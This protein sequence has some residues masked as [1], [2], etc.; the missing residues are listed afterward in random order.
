MSGLVLELQRDALNQNVHISDLL[1]K[2]FVVSRKLNILDIQEWINNELNGYPPEEDKIPEYR[3]LHGIPKVFNP[4]HGWQPLNF[5][6]L[7]ISDLLSS[8]KHPHPVGELD[9]L[10]SHDGSN[11]LYLQYPQQVT[12]WLINQMG[13]PMQPALLIPRTKIIGIMESVRN[14]VLDWSLELESKGILGEGMSFS[15]KEKQ[16]ASSITYQVTNNIGHMN[17]SQLQQHSE[18]SNQTINIS[19]NL[20]NIKIFIEGLKSAMKDL[21]LSEPDINEL[22]AEV[23]TIDN[24][25]ASPKPKAVIINESLKSIRNLLEGIAVNVL[26]SNLLAQ[27]TSLC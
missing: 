27:L 20:D 10:I 19:T 23:S 21:P 7:E 4:Y 6:N 8:R 26:S 2:A 12:N 13:V 11:S 15:E 16:T 25:I 14:K 3:R 22:K 17:N 18:N 9:N 1:R 5:E 24:Q